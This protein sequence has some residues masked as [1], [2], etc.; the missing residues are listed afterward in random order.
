MS[1][2]RV[3]V[4]EASVTAETGRAVACLPRLPA[5]HA[6]RSLEAA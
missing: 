2:E 6:G 5:Q 1:L 3:S 4:P